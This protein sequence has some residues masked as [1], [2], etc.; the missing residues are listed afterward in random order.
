MEVVRSGQSYAHQQAGPPMSLWLNRLLPVGA[1]PEEGHLGGWIPVPHS[2]LPAPVFLG[3][4]EEPLSS[5]MGFFH[6]TSIL[7][8]ELCKDFLE[9]SPQ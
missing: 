5:A 7:E 9:Q 2:S 6:A 8:P 3:I 4:T 1:W